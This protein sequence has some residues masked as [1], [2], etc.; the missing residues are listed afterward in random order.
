MKK[1]VLF[2]LILQCVTLSAQE[3]TE[4]AGPMK[5]FL[6]L[7][8][9]T[10]ISAK[11]PILICEDYCYYINRFTK[12][13][14][15]QKLENI[16]GFSQGGDVRWIT[17]EQFRRVGRTKTKGYFWAFVLSSPPIFIGMPMFLDLVK[18]ERIRILYHYSLNHR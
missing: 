7:K 16:E 15:H 14:S 11:R 18:R 1:Y 2:V 3:F 13:P 12:I 6:Q 10:I 5:P 8:D 9:G 4:D 17:K